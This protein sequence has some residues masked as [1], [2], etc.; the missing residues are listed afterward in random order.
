[1]S[2]FAEFD[3]KFNGPTNA[4]EY[5][6]EEP[7]KRMRLDTRAANRFIIHAIKQTQE[8]AKDIASKLRAVVWAFNLD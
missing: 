6:K 4:F 8:I 2:V 3:G 1:M 7:A 5:I